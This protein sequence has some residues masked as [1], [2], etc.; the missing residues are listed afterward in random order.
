MSLSSIRTEKDEKNE[1]VEW[2]REQVPFQVGE[3][4]WVWATFLIRFLAMSSE[5]CP[6]WEL[7]LHQNWKNN[8][9][10]SNRTNTGKVLWENRLEKVTKDKAI[11]Q[12]VEKLKMCALSHQWF[13]SGDGFLPLPPKG[14]Y[15][16][17]LREVSDC[18]SW[19]QGMPWQRPGTLVNI[20]HS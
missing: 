17:M 2:V 3:K 19:G 9:V 15:G 11:C 8:R 6:I 1:Y 12:C 13:S 4:V 20:L 14:I 18:H 5:Q 16:N 10:R 7:V